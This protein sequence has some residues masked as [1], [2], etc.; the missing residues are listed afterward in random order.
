[1]RTLTLTTATTAFIVI[2]ALIAPAV[3]AQGQTEYCYPKPC[4]TSEAQKKLKK[5]ESGTTKSHGRGNAR[6]LKR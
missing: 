6:L 3:I 2:T 4:P 1:M 5:K